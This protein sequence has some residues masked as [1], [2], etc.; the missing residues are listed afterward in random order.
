[1]AGLKVGDAAPAWRATSDDGRE[2][3]SADLAGRRYV[4]YF[5]PRDDTPGCTREA[6]NFRDSFARL[7]GVG[8]EVFGVSTDTVARHER[9]KQKHAL[10]FTLLADP[11]RRIITAFGAEGS[12]STARRMTF[13]IG[14]D[15]RIERVWPRVKMKGHVEEILRALGRPV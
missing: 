7:R 2:V 8:V 10:P 5:Y 9:F 4:L 15:G 6:C 1:M 3:E 11:E 12:L 13:L 14:P